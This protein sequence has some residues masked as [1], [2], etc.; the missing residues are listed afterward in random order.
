VVLPKGFVAIGGK[1]CSVGYEPFEEYAAVEDFQGSEQ[2]PELVEGKSL[3]HP[4]LSYY[5]MHLNYIVIYLLLCINVMAPIL[6]GLTSVVY[7]ALI[8]LGLLYVG[9]TC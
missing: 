9:Y 3:L 4:H 1:P 8:N 2:F 5:N 7:H 6:V